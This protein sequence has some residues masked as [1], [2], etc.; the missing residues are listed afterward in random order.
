MLSET[1]TSFVEQAAGWW[2]A[3]T[4][5]VSAVVA[6]VLVSLTFGMVGSLVVGNRMA[7]FSDAMVHSAFAGVAIGMLVY[8]LAGLTRRAD[9]VNEWV[10]VL[11]MVLFGVAV[12][13]GIEFVRERTGL[14]NDTVIGV[15]FAVVTGFAAL[16]IPS[17]AQ[18]VRF[19]NPEQFLFGSLLFISPEQ[20]GVFFVMLPLTAAVI[21]VGY[22][23]FAFS[24]FSP[25]LARSRGKWVRVGNYVFIVLLAIVVNIS[26]K[27]V[28]ALLINA[29]L[30]VPAAGAANVARNLR[31]MFWFSVL[32]SVGSGLFGYFI[33]QRYNISLG[34]VTLQPRPAGAV[35]LA[36]VGWFF[37]T[38]PAAAL[39]KRIARAGHN[40]APGNGSSACC[41]APT[42]ADD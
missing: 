3:T 31:Q 36:A 20:L 8:V 40:H 11:A 12:G 13:L 33:C 16:L 29:L 18:H 41:P 2:G 34:K 21:A 17:L 10:I 19:F 32:A 1:I 30:I 15:F 14:A 25:L 27:A 26:I 4:Y 28:G 24:S 38:M 9:D 37:L 23:T 7:F 5:E 22:N 35:V 6:L 39:H 42:P